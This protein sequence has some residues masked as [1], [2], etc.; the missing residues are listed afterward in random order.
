[1]AFVAVTVANGT[2]DPIF[3]HEGASNFPNARKFPRWG[4]PRG[5][6]KSL[7]FQFALIETLNLGKTKFVCTC[8]V[9]RAGVS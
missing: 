2:N 3:V 8:F 9:I 7:L 1:M 5:P 6:W 4:C